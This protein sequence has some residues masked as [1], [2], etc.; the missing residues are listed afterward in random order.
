MS[1][2]SNKTYSVFTW[3]VGLTAAMTGNHSLSFDTN[4]RVRTKNQRGSPFNSPFFNTVLFRFWK[5]R[6][7]RVVK[8]NWIEVVTPTGSSSTPFP[9]SNLVRSQ[10]NHPLIQIGFPLA[11]PSD[12]LLALVEMVIFQRSQ[13]QE[14]NLHRI[15]RLVP[16][17]SPFQETNEPSTKE[18]RASNMLSPLFKPGLLWN[19]QGFVCFL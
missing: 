2:R 16:P 11:T 18:N 7:I 13:H 3:T 4:I 6:I 9:G 14:L 17:H 19:S 12:S 8:K 1:S 5:R 15:L 10:R